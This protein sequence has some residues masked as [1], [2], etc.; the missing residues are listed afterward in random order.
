MNLQPPTQHWCSV[1][2][3]RPVHV[4]L[5]WRCSREVSVSS[6]GEKQKSFPSS[7]IPSDLRVF[8]RNHDGLLRYCLD[9]G[10]KCLWNKD[11]LTCVKPASVVDIGV[12][13]PSNSLLASGRTLRHTWRTPCMRHRLIPCG[14]L[15]VWQTAETWDR[16]TSTRA[17]SAVAQQSLIIVKSS[18]SLHDRD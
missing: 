1:A 4:L 3:E 2:A 10:W 12:V 14:R 11:D 5:T 7:W 8:W 6:S 18:E 9:D 17:M 13:S 15:D 16:L